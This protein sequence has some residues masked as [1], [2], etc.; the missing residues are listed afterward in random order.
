[1]ILPVIG[2]NSHIG[3]GVHLVGGIGVAGDHHVGACLTITHGLVCLRYWTA[4]YVLWLWI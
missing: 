3:A 1:M 2:G 4:T